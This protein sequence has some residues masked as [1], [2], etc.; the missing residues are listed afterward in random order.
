[1]HRVPVIDPYLQRFRMKKAPRTGG[2]LQRAD[3]VDMKNDWK[4]VFPFTQ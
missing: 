3:V 1:V 2:R 4:R